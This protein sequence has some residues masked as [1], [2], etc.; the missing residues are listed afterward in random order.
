MFRIGGVSYLN[1]RPL[2]LP[3]QERFVFRPLSP[4][5]GPRD[6]RRKPLPPESGIVGDEDVGNEN[7]DVGNE[8]KKGG[9]KGN[10]EK[11]DG[12]AE[13]EIDLHIGRAERVLY[14]NAVPS[15]LAE[16]LE[17]GELDCSLLS[18]IEAFR[19]PGAK[20]LSDAA[21]A[22]EGPV[23]SVRLFGRVPFSDVRRI[24]LD[25]GSRT[26]VVL[27]QILM[28][29][30]LGRPV[31]YVSFPLDTPME[32][33]DADACL[34]IGDRGMRPAEPPWNVWTLDLAG[35][36][37]RMTGLPFVF[38]VWIAHPGITRSEKG[39]TRVD[40]SRLARCLSEARDEGVRR[41]EEIAASEG[42]KVGITA[43]DALDY[44]RYALRFRLGVREIAGLTMFARLAAEDGLIDTPEPMSFVMDSPDKL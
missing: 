8:E 2:T 39:E 7:G 29:R 20:I 28:K 6:F 1:S 5:S 33:V 30:R 36:W 44:F 9:R 22:A 10:A 18:S 42:P 13:A 37:K 31:E 15:R 23:R 26:S 32:M 19:L 12:S 35:E 16:L 34:S 21:I 24:A 14:C 40:L 38:A 3:L 43:S 4:E 27:T 41:L 17:A 11:W 25:A